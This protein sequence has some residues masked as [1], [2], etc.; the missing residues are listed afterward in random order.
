MNA[1]KECTIHTKDGQHFI[2]VYADSDRLMVFPQKVLRLN[3]QQRR[4]CAH[5][6][7][8]VSYE[9]TGHGQWGRG[10]IKCGALG[11]T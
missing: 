9:Y 11:R 6:W 1:C 3:R 8:R 2:Y 4:K 10:C 7:C 5:Q